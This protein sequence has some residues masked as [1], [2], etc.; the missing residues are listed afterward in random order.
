MFLHVLIL[1]FALP[2]CKLTEI[3]VTKIVYCMVT[4]KFS[5]TKINMGGP[6]FMEESLIS[7]E[8]GDPRVSKILGNWGPGSLIS[9]ENGD[10]GSPFSC[11]T[12]RQTVEAWHNCQEPKPINRD[13]G[14][15]PPVYDSLIRIYPPPDTHL[16]R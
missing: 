7:Y 11:D 13:K 2:T 5:K 10:P 14:L 9:Y 16:C 1:Y 6:N 12:H 15:L 3:K 8:I 4:A